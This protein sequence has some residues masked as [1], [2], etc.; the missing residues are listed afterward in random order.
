MSGCHKLMTMIF[1]TLN[2]VKKIVREVFTL[3]LRV[4][5]QYWSPVRGPPYGPGPQTAL[6]TGPRTTPMDLL[7]GPPQNNIEIKK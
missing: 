5:R 7:Y 6:R 4:T 3:N 2:I 1:W